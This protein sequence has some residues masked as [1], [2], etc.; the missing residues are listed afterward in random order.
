MFIRAA[1]ARSPR[2]ARA[3]LAL[4]L[5]AAAVLIGSNGC[6]HTPAVSVDWR[7]G[8]FFRPTNYTGVAIMPAEIRRVAVLPLA[9][10]EGLPPESTEPL[11]EALAAALLATARFEVVAVDG[12]LLRAAGGRATVRSTEP[13]PA[14]LFE[15]IAREHAP[16][17][18]LFVE[19][20][21]YQPY[22]PLVLGVRAKLVSGDGSHAVL[23]AF[24]TLYDARVPAVANSARRHAAGGGREA[25]DVGPA[26]VQS[27]RRFAAY[28]FTDLCS[29]LPERPPPLPAKVP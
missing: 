13:L 17:A 28:V 10:L 22:A 27:P 7:G 4:A 2:S 20:T 1:S 16:D 15:R 9:G 18:V 12:A 8:P 5:G 11:R 19:V 26:G 24:D 29:C 3:R 23:W 25:V 21:H 6:Q 14:G